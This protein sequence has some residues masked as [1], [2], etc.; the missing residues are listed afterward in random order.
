MTQPTTTSVCLGWYT[1]GVLLLVPAP[2]VFADFSTAIERVSP[3]VAVVYARNG[4]TVGVGSGFILS[5]EG[6]IATNHHV[7]SGASEIRVELATGDTYIATTLVHVDEAR[8]LAVIKIPA[9]DLRPV[10]L[11]N[12]NNLKVGQTVLAVG[13]PRGLTA[14]T[15]AGIISAIR[16]DPGGYRLIQTDAAVNPGNSGGPLLNSKGEVVGVVVGRIKGAEGLNFAIPVNYLRGL[17]GDRPINVSLISGSNRGVAKAPIPRPS[18]SKPVAPPVAQA[19]PANSSALFPTSCTQVM[20]RVALICGD[21]HGATTEC[22]FAVGDLLL[23]RCLRNGSR[24]PCR[25]A[26]D[27]VPYYCNYYSAK[28]LCDAAIESVQAHCSD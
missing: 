1:A 26:V 14:T 20:D 17:L 8:D 6:L 24:S 3:S 23:A 28:N 11:G 7:I 5:R 21:N 25:A 19:A 2:A 4:D 27:G 9:F 18:D 12:S 13:A 22:Q 16:P 15:T 10:V